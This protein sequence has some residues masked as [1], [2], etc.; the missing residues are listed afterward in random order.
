[1]EL[2]DHVNN[3]CMDKKDIP[4]DDLK[5]Y[6]T[7]MISRF[8]SSVDMYL[9]V[10]AEMNKY[11]LPKQS[12]ARILKTVLPDYKVY[13][14]LIKKKKVD[15]SLEDM[16][17]KYYKVGS[18]DAKILLGKL[19]DQDIKELKEYYECRSSKKS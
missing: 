1:M 12:H 4:E 10:V 3:L 14:P 11:D 8:V 6:D 5:T 19:T 2:F 18:E 15:T 7:Y 13:F 17:G 16:V 9:P